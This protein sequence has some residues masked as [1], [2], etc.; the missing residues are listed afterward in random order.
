MTIYD[1]IAN[2]SVYILNCDDEYEYITN[3]NCRLPNEDSETKEDIILDN[4][5]EEG[6]FL[7]L[8]EN[9]DWI[10]DYIEKLKLDNDYISLIKVLSK[11]DT[12]INGDNATYFDDD[13]KV[14]SFDPLNSSFLEEVII[15]PKLYNH[16]NWST[17]IDELSGTLNSLLTNIL[18]V[19]T[20]R[21]N[22]YN[23]INHFV[24]SN[25]SNRNFVVGG[26]PVTSEIII[27]QQ[28]S[29]ENNC[30]NVIFDIKYTNEQKFIE[31]VINMLKLADT[32]YVSC[33]AFPEMIS[34][35]P[36]NSKILS[37]INN[38]IFT[39]IKLIILPTY[40]DSE[41]KQ[42]V[43]EIYFTETKS[44][45]I[46]Q[47]KSFSFITDLKQKEMLN[48]NKQ[49]H[50]LHINGVGRVMFPICKDM[51]VEKYTQIC[52]VIRAN[53][54]ITRSFS[55]NH[56]YTCFERIIKA[57][58]SFE[59]NVFWINSCNQS[60]TYSIYAHSKNVGL[61]YNNS[62]FCDKVCEECIASFIAN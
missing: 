4:L 8:S 57:Y 13:E 39:N 52:R 20:K 56:S 42:N 18:I 45:I 40:Y 17:N 3:F 38:L 9:F 12:L 22:G 41:T 35:K 59:C 16:T 36:I 7:T 60:K 27:E 31:Q 51:L 19:D 28:E 29:S 21:L 30:K 58:T 23:L 62:C 11:L 53:L 2:I 55:I 25:Y 33:F 47:F 10:I 48:K 61:E 50:I 6:S 43:G 44:I 37:R 1:V 24:S 15:L 46:R 54:V 32:K 14:V 26:S 49:I 5:I 34:T